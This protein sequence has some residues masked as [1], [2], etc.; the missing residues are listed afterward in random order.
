MPG[1]ICAGGAVGI[2]GDL[3]ASWK[4]W[5]Q[6]RP[7]RPFRRS[8]FLNATAVGRSLLVSCGTAPVDVSIQCI[9]AARAEP[10]PGL[11]GR[12]PR[13]PLFLGARWY[14]RGAAVPASARQW[15][16]WLSALFCPRFTRPESRACESAGPACHH[17]H[18]TRHRSSIPAPLSSPPSPRPTIQTAGIDPYS[19]MG[20]FIRRA[21]AAFKGD[22]CEVLGRGDACLSGRSVCVRLRMVWAYVHACACVCGGATTAAYS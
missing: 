4:C 2:R 8:P 5:G 9:G 12:G 7:P 10:P 6:R 13:D 3:Q 16:I 14:A 1:L 18:L 15:L 22:S 21:C 19:V 17:D 20:M 11:G